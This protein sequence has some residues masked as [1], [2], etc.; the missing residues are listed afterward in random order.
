[1][2]LFF[3]SLGGPSICFLCKWMGHETHIACLYSITNCCR[4]SARQHT[5]L[6]VLLIPQISL[7]PVSCANYVLSR[8]RIRVGGCVCPNP[9]KK[10]SFKSFLKCGGVNKI[11]SNRVRTHFTSHVCPCVQ[12]LMSTWNS[13]DRNLSEKT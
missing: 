1:M 6:D 9:G 2:R 7:D 10:S 5:I 11:F 13:S 8:S 12:N 4:A 3:I